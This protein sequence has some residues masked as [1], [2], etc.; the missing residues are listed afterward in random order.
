MNDVFK[1]ISFL[2]KSYISIISSHKIWTHEIDKIPINEKKN[3]YAKN[4]SKSN[5][6]NC[7]KTKYD[8][9]KAYDNQVIMQP[10]IHIS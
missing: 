7:N 10:N 8:F 9:I 1:L 5:N 3:A 2:Y 6:T 4:N